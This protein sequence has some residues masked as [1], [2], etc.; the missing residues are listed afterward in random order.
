MIIH[1]HEYQV[2]QIKSTVGSSPPEP[3]DALAMLVWQYLGEQNPIISGHTEGIDTA[4]TK[5][6][7][8]YL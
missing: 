2:F 4:K 7:K 5:A 1:V 3:L 8:R 6:K